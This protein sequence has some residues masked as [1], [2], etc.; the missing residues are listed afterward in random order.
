[1]TLV[2]NLQ[3]R[4]HASY[5]YNDKIVGASFIFQRLCFVC[6]VAMNQPV[7]EDSMANVTV[8][9][10]LVALMCIFQGMMNIIFHVL[11]SHL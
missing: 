8:R 3:D 6:F 1:M 4:L 9:W 11:K 10:L 7:N 2:L 5:L